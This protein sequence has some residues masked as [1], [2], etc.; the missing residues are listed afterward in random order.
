MSNSF[1][2]IQ[3]FIPKALIQKYFLEFLLCARNCIV[4]GSRE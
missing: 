4:Q 1:A 2:F 3:S